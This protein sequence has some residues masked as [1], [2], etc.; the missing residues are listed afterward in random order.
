MPSTQLFL[1]KVF[2]TLP[3]D[4][5]A[6]EIVSSDYAVI[7]ELNRKFAAQSFHQSPLI[8]LLKLYDVSLLDHFDLMTQE[9]Q[10]DALNLINSPALQ[11][12][13]GINLANVK[14]SKVQ[15]IQKQKIDIAYVENQL[16]T[17]HWR[18]SFNEKLSFLVSMFPKLSKEDK[19]K[20]IALSE[21]GLYQISKNSAE[22][23]DKI[24]FIATMVKTWFNTADVS[25]GLFQCERIEPE[26]MPTGIT[27]SIWNTLIKRFAPIMEE[28]FDENTGAS[29]GMKQVPHPHAQSVF[30]FVNDM[31]ALSLM[32]PSFLS[33]PEALKGKIIK[34]IAYMVSIDDLVYLADHVFGQEFIAVSMA[35]F[36]ENDADA[37]KRELIL[38]LIE[39]H[40]TVIPQTEIEEIDLIFGDDPAPYGAKKEF[41]MDSLL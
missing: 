4:V 33:L 20:A 14:T 8:V 26:D 23:R 5:Q 3:N 16:L 40:L 6:R 10:E 32:S 31:P 38:N 21:I 30:N 41:T 37:D 24:R 13:L 1:D 29:L 28:E 2:T 11:N 12:A 9:A 34:G 39:Q 15:D 25:F 7:G 22:K 35:L 36:G 19:Q 18:S 27:Y 17:T